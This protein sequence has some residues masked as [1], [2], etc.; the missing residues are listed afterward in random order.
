MICIYVNREYSR[1]YG[2]IPVI[3]IIHETL[4]QKYKLWYRV[5]FLLKL[6][7]TEQFK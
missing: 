2:A 4:Y 7:E 3:F 1:Q 6:Q 5:S